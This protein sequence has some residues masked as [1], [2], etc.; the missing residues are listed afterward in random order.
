MLLLF[1]LCAALLNAAQPWSVDDLQLWRE[2]VEAHISPDG[3][4]VAW[5]ESSR[6]CTTLWQAA[7][8]APKPRRLHENACRESLPRWS[9]DSRQ[10]AYVSDG[11]IW[12]VGVSRPLARLASPPLT[13]S[14]S[15]DSSALTY[16]LREPGRDPEMYAVP[17]GSGAPRRI[18]HHPGPDLSSL[19]SPDGSRIA[20]VSRDAKPQSYVIAKLHVANADGSRAKVLAGALDRD[21]T[22]IQW[23]SDSRTIYFLAD[24]RGAT[25]VWSARADGSVRQVTTARERLTGFSLADNG[26][27]VA[28]HPDGEIFT[29]PVDV[30]G[31]PSTLASPNADLLAARITSP[32]EEIRFPSDGRTIQGWI[33]KPPAFDRA[34]RYPLILD[35]QD[36][37]RRMCGVEFSL[38]TQILAARGFV[39][40]CANPR[41]TPGFG[42]EFGNLLRARDPG[43]DF[44]DLMRAADY[45]VAKGLADPARIHII[46]G[47]LAAW[48]IGQTDRFRSAVAVDPVVV[49]GGGPLRSPINYADNFR[50]PTL[51]IDTGVGP[52]AS[53]LYSAL[54]ARRIDTELL[55]LSGAPQLESILSW[56]TR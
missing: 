28:V 48:A 18:A 43:D 27:A 21:V 13:L 52:G 39:V 10:L 1:L 50:T 4:T 45:L 12:I 8:A 47:L 32:P 54:Q 16:V 44:D 20:W 35:V 23:S 29:F 3:S 51:V 40:L 11:Q 24:D 14:W 37:P 17:V 5:V 46:G 42:E 31:A 15:P 26:R 30:A 55:T 6:G 2:V 36:A 22:H 41:G 33:V 38:R 56:L 53:A 19:P 49:Y 34:R 25:H 9:P 7:T